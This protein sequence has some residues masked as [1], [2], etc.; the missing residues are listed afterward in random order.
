ML[1]CMILALVWVV[2]AFMARTLPERFHWF[3]AWALIAT[4]IPLLGFITV[5][6]GPVFG[7]VGL[8][9]AGALLARAI[10]VTGLSGSAR[11]GKI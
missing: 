9:V 11:V 7:V 4:G 10:R 3:T 1:I 6:A 8:A 2:A 5:Q